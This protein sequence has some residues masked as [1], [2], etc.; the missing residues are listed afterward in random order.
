MVRHTTRLALT[1]LAGIGGMAGAG[2]GAQPNESCV[3]IA[4]IDPVFAPRTVTLFGELHGTNEA[5][6]FLANV[7]CHATVRRLPVM[8]AIELPKE[9]TAALRRYVTSAGTAGDRTTLLADAAWHMSPADGRASGAMLRLVETTRRLVS[10][11]GDVDVFA[12]SD[13]PS[14]TQTRDSQMAV[15]LADAVQAASPRD[16]N[17]MID[18]YGAHLQYGESLVFARALSEARPHLEIAERLARAYTVRFPSDANAQLRLGSVLHT[19]GSLDRLER[20]P[21]A[22][23]AFAEELVIRR[24]LLATDPRSARRRTDLAIALAATGA[25]DEAASLVAAVAADTRPDAEL[26][27]DHAR[28][29][30]Q[31]AGAGTPPGAARGYREQALT[32]L[33]QAVAAGYRDRVYVDGDPDFAALRGDPRV[34]A[35]FSAPPATPG[36]VAA[37]GRVPR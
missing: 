32:A 10:E 13:V 11:N 16:P 14:G 9:S 29:Y 22:A 26:L 31:C 23:A 6:A 28:A 4:G 27:V 1:L 19:R 5:P 12:F 25:C 24:R 17:V 30:A 37:S 36:A 8:L 2:A 34:R 7:L 35:M 3:P 20:R 33:G 15:I 21:S 18:V